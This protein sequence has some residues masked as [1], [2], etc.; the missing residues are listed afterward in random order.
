V[1]FIISI[2]DIPPPSP[3]LQFG[4]P[5][6]MAAASST[7]YHGFS[8]C[9]M[10]M[11]WS[12]SW[13]NPPGLVAFAH[14][15]SPTSKATRRLGALPVP[16]FA[17]AGLFYQ[18]GNPFPELLPIPLFASARGCDCHS[19]GQSRPGL[20]RCMEAPPR[21][22]WHGGPPSPCDGPPAIST[23]LGRR[24]GCRC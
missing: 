3:W 6:A 11:A 2:L 20:P 10:S 24:H 13:N 8:W 4:P 15:M 12:D 21:R 14:N 16:L 5:H 17:L 19:R 1:I 23:M 9:A 22:L 7:L 18:S